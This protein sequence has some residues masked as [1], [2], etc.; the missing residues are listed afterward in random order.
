MKAINP[1]IPLDYPDP[2]VIRVGDRYY[3]VSTTMHFFPGCEI[4]TSTDL[5]TW[6]HLCFVYDTLDSTPGQQLTDKEG[7]YGKGMWAASLRYHEGLFYVLFSANDTQ[8][9]YLFTSSD[10][11]SHWTKQHIKGFYHDPSLLFDDDGKVYIIYGNTDI[12]LTELNEEL[13]GPK[14][15]GINKIIISEPNPIL[16]YE[17]AHAYKINDTYYIFL[18]SSLPDKWMRV[19]SCFWSKEIDGDYKGKLILKDDSGAP[20]QGIAQGGI[21]SSPDGDWYMILFQDRGAVGRLL[22][23]VPFKWKEGVPVIGPDEKLAEKPEELPNKSLN[24]VQLI[25]SDDFK[26]ETDSF[27]GLKPCWQFN[28]EPDKENYE[29]NPREGYVEIRHSE[30]VS[31]LTQARNTLTQRMLYP[32]SSAEVTI[33]CS[34]LK[35]GD[36]AGLCALQGVYGFIGVTR[37]D[38]SLR[39][40]MRNVERDSDTD[41]GLQ[42][43]ETEQESIPLTDN[44]VTLKIDAD[45]S[46]GRDSAVFSFKTKTMEGFKR[47]GPEHQLY[48][49]LDHFT[50]CRYGLFSY[51]TEE[52][53]GRSRFKMFVYHQM[54]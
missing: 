7:I 42:L 9:T 37:A 32:A 53:G 28:H 38:S 2:D 20:G 39:V 10:P 23:L 6:D 15:D 24:D 3:M 21:V 27:Y 30:I 14:T 8:K 5:V 46:N 48:F 4:L 54:D 29:L 41:S 31:N 43:N 17:G 25:S 26:T 16:G 1:L 35:D 49:G 36:I 51:A 47:V 34:Q 52:T 13:T 44:E 12:W 11:A 40:V 18:I 22:V 33:D 50:G 19:Q 45:F